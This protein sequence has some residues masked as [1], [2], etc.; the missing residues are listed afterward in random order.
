MLLPLSCYGF[1]QNITHHSFID[2]VCCCP[3][4]CLLSVVSQEKLSACPSIDKGGYYVSSS[5]RRLVHGDVCN[6]GLSALIPDTDG[7]G[8]LNPGEAAAQGLVIV[9]LNSRGL[10]SAR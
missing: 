10:N 2:G 6:S 8:T 4:W 1:H 9:W 5:G 7:K 3:V